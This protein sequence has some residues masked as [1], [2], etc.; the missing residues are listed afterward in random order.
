[1]DASRKNVAVLAICQ[2]LLLTNNSIL[3]TVNALVGCTLASNRA[4]ATLPLTAGGCAW[5]APA[6]R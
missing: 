2:G 5:G 1:M 3:I 4:I 6:R